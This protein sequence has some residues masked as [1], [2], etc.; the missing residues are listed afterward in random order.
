[1]ESVG[2]EELSPDPAGEDG[3]DKATGKYVFAAKA[4]PPIVFNQLPSGRPFAP[5]DQY[6][7]S[8]WNTY[9]R[10][11]YRVYL[12]PTGTWAFR[13]G[14]FDLT[15][16]PSNAQ[17]VQNFGQGWGNGTLGVTFIRIV[18]GN[19]VEAD[20]ALNPAIP[21]TLDIRQSTRGD[22]STFLFQHTMLHEIGHAWGLQHPWETQNVWW[23]SVLNYSPKAYRVG[24]LLADDTAAVRQAYPG[25]TL[26]DLLISSYLTVDTVNNLN[27]TYVPALPS[28]TRLQAG[29]GFALRTSIKIENVGTASIVNPSVEVYLTPA[30]FSFAGAIFL[31]TASYRTT[32]LSGHI[33]Y[34][35]LGTLTIPRSAR[36]GT[37]FLAYFVRDPAD[38]VQTNNYSWSDWNVTV[39][40][41]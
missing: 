16:F 24:E 8:Y 9:A 22:N 7:M 12:N 41:R 28:A 6:Q 26:R 31:K 21:W 34:L 14:V 30:R 35:N 1:V 15:G 23:D 32:V 5:Y 17:L 11:L 36:S 3:L 18:G 33:A 19:I 13:N 2:A 10:N 20:V 38:S 39:T 27:A 25:T 40:V 29:S 4:T 37:Y